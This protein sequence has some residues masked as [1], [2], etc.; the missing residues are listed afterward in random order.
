MFSKR[1]TLVTRLAS[2]TIAATM[3]LAMMLSINL[4]ATG[5]VHAGQLARST[6]SVQVDCI[7]V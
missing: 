6:P 3:T 4:L 5:E 1:N 7:P 2:M